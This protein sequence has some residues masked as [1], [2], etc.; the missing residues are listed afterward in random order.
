MTIQTI[1]TAIAGTIALVIVPLM[2]VGLLYS[3]YWA[4]KRS[5]NM[6][7]VFDAFGELASC[8]Y[9]P[10]DVVLKCAKEIEQLTKTKSNKLVAI[11]AESTFSYINNEMEYYYRKNKFSK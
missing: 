6:K 7:K 2:I 1:N 11:K 10:C 3:T 5:N 8:H 4:T 9:V